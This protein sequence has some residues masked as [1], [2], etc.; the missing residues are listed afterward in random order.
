MIFCRFVQAHMTASFNELTRNLFN[1]KS[2]K[3]AKSVQNARLVDVIMS[4][5]LGIIVRAA[6]FSQ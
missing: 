4:T 2:T 5:P 6:L 1:G 3:C